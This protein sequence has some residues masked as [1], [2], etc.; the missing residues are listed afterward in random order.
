MLLVTRNRANQV[1]AAPRS[2]AVLRWDAVIVDQ[3][4]DDDTHQS[5]LRVVEEDRRFR[6]LRSN[7]T[8]SS[9]ARNIAITEARGPLQAFTDDVRDVAPGWLDRLEPYFQANDDDNVGLV[10]GSVVSGRHDK[11]CGFIPDYPVAQADRHPPC[12]INHSHHLE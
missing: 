10:Y 3:S 1:A 5:I 4:Q 11:Q 8:G 2:V 6:Y 7:S 9:V 12:G